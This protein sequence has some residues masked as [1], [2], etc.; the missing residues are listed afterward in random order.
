MNDP[1][2]ANSATDAVRC[3]YLSRVARRLG[4]QRAAERWNARAIRWLERVD[5]RYAADAPP[6][7]NSDVPAD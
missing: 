5:G 4:H 1:P 6:A 3:L 7:I 2:Q